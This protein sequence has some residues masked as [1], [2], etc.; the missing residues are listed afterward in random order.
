MKRLYILIALFHVAVFGL[1]QQPIT[2]KKVEKFFE[3]VS[4][5]ERPYYD[6]LLQLRQMGDTAFTVASPNFDTH[7]FRCEW[8]VDPNVDSIRGKITSAFTITS[9]TNN[10]IFDLVNQLNVDSVFYHGAPIPF[11]H[12][13]NGLTLH[14]PATLTSGTFDSLSIFYQ[15][16]PPSTGFG[17]YV[18]KFHAGIPVIWTLS[19]PYGARDWWPCKNGLTDKTDSAD[20][21]ITCPQQYHASSNGVVRNET[22]VGNNRITFFQHRYPIATYLLALA[23]TNY[24]VWRDTVLLNG[25]VMNMKSYYYPE[26]S[27]YFA[28]EEGFTKQFLQ[29]FT[30]LFGEYPFI[31]EKYGHT[32][33]GWGG[34]QEHQTNSFIT[35][36]NHS[37]IAHEMGH[38]WFGDWVTC[39][40]WADIWLNEGFATY[41]QS[42]TAEY[43]FPDFV[44]IGLQEIINNITLQP[45]GSVYVKD[46]TN[47][48][49][50]FNSKLSY[51]K[52]FYVLYMLR[53][54]L[55]DSIFYRGL[56]R[57]LNDP[58][59]RGGFARTA[60]FERNMELESGRDLTVFFQKWVYG[61]GFPSYKAVWSQNTNQW[62]KVVLNQTTSHPSVSFYEM[63]VRLELKGTKGDS[64]FVVD[65]RF[66]GQEFWLNPGFAVDTIIIDPKLQILSNSKISTKAPT[67]IIINDLSIYPNPAPQQVTVSL[68]NPSDSKLFLQLFNA[69]GQLLYN[70]EQDT[71]G[72]DELISIPVSQYP[73]GVYLLRLRSEKNIHTVKKIVR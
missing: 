60:D 7:Y 34:G 44:P 42:L 35:T 24:S 43:L 47:P 1:A 55:G 41:A 65:H 67:S 21:I 58:A 23:V 40:S 59:V 33:F 57:Y 69:I 25:K 46:T 31:K 9:N 36:P 39:G 45:G 16:I 48:S 4:T 54:V 30:S 20:I 18:Q 32:E 28:S 27:I 22:I 14:F 71:P 51:D 62:V 70:K 61:E 13:N 5:H 2:Q 17:S 37:L 66:T 68:K 64:T 56:R 19:E 49:N 3:E 12:S 15:G 26:D 52:G 53:G 38:Q 8:Y 29:I 11:D 6:R 10:I 63:P 73:H 72:R 50:I